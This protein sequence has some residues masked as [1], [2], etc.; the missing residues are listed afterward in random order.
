[1]IASCIG[2][3]NAEMKH[4]SNRKD[5]IQFLDEYLVTGPTNLNDTISL[6]IQEQLPNDMCWGG[7]MLQ[8]ILVFLIEN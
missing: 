3:D 5:I 2:L 7:I 1:M 6:Y 4:K 8:G